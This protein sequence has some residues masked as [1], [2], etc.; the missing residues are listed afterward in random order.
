MNQ[1]SVFAE[2]ERAGW[3]SK[4]LVDAWLRHFGPLTD[5][6]A[7]AL[8]ERA[9]PRGKAALDLCCGAG[10][11]SARLAEAGA[12][13][14]G[15]DFSAEMLR[16]ARRAAAGAD[17]RAGDAAALPFADARFDLALCSFGMMHLPDQP[18][19]LLEVRRVLR[20][21]GRFLTAV[22][23]GPETSPAF[24][25]M[26]RAL[27][28]LGDMSAAPP[29]PDPFV[30]ARRRSAAALMGAAGLQLEGH[31]VIRPAWRLKTPSELFDIF[32][33]ASV[34]VDMML[35]AQRPEVVDAIRLRTSEAIAA[36]Y[37]GGEDFRV[38]APAVILEARAV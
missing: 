23:A 1:F 10:R 19:A 38:E 22:W 33:A 28:E 21:G 34:T 29:Q 14:S 3:A 36:Q 8:V 17:L 9:S 20:P 6:V 7:D 13:V 12:K 37:D 31:E 18:A 26:M 11:L 15:L 32:R 35:K 5:E 2:R 16:R 27:R 24:G 4:P 30:F 25:A